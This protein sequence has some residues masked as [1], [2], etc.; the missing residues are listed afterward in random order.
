M[1]VKMLAELGAGR[2][3]GAQIVG[4]EGSAKRID[5]CALALWNE[6][7][8]DELM[9]TDLSYAPPFSPVWDPV[10]TAARA[11]AAKLR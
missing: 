2:L 11:V 7:T 6:M 9:Q 5:T 4:R 8:V 3:L 1:T 10:Q